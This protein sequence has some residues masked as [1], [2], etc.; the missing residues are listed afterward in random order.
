M[1]RRSTSL[2]IDVECV[3][4]SLCLYKLSHDLVLGVFLIRTLSFY[5]KPTTAK[6]PT[7]LSLEDGNGPSRRSG[8]HSLLQCDL[9][10]LS[11]L[12]LE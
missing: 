10:V 4:L 2:N 8:R 6:V 12:V 1:G 3:Y 7:V 5:G 9:A 11:G